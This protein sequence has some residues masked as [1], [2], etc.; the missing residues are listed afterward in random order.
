MVIISIVAST[1]PILTNGIYLG[2]A[3]SHSGVA[4]AVLDT[5]PAFRLTS[6]ALSA[7]GLG[8]AIFPR[9][10]VYFSGES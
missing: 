3:P 4:L 5:S 2:L 1:F 7:L 10:L 6:H 8:S 9:S